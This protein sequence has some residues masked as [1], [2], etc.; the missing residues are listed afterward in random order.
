MKKAPVHTLSKWFA[1]SV[2]ATRRIGPAVY[3]S[4]LPQHWSIYIV[5][6]TS[7]LKPF[8]TSTLPVFQ[9]LELDDDKSCV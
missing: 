4:E 2:F 5:I 1:G 7:F 6:H 8:K 9:E 3:Q